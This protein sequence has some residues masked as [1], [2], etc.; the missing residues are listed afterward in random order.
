MTELER[1]IN[2]IPISEPTPI[3]P[4]NTKGG[5]VP[6]TLYDALSIGYQRDEDMQ[7]QELKK[8]GFNVD[9]GLSNHDHLTAYNPES[10]KLLYVVNGTQTTRIPDLVTDANLVLGRLKQT[11]R[12]KSDKRQ[13]DKAREKYGQNEIIIAAHSLGSG[14]GRYLDTNKN[15]RVLSY[16]GAETFGQKPNPREQSFR[17]ANDLVSALKLKSKIISQ[18][19]NGIPILDAH[20]LSNLKGERI[21]I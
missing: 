4:I 5:P 13:Y 16:N 18:K 1:R 7:E 10:K 20:E 9:K 21:F 6:L 15:V 2:P 8:Y 11:K 19:V 3:E 14:I 12:Y 17:T